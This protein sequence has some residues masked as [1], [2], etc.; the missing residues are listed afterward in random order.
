MTCQGFIQ[1]GSH[2]AHSAKLLPFLILL[3]FLL[4]G[5]GSG[6][7]EEGVA[8]LLLVLTVLG[9]ERLPHNEPARSQEPSGTGA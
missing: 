8:H 7:G 6:G 4:R 1:P 3:L 5:G 9:A 2:P